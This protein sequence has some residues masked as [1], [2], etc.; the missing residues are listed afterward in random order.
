MNRIKEWLEGVAEAFVYVLWEAW[1]WLVHP[2][3]R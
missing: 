2:R 3:S 1:D